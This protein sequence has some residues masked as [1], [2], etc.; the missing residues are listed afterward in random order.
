MCSGGRASPRFFLLGG[1]AL[2]LLAA[3]NGRAQEIINPGF[4]K[5]LTD[6]L[7]RK[8]GGMSAAVQVAAR[9]GSYGLRITDNDPGKGSRLE[10]LPIEV[11]P[12]RK[13]E[14]SFWARTVEG[15]GGVTVT[16]GFLDEKQKFLQ[17]KGPLTIARP[18]A[19]WQ[20]FTLQARAPD[21][22]VA[23]VIWIQSLPQETVTMDL[24]DFEYRELP[25]ATP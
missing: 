6:W 12:G 16:L 13:Y 8:D 22:S 17:K 10:S 1:L 24:D 15:G 3:L 11:V 20:R 2:V 19:E 5:D 18:S 23:F 14:V 25:E 4:E 21:N 9:S 7:A